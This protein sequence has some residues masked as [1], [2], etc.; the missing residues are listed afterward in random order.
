MI[1]KI[2]KFPPIVQT[3]EID[4]S[5][6]VTLFV[7][8]NNAG[9][10]YISQLVWAINN[11]DPSSSE[12]I[13]FEQDS[14]IRFI[15]EGI[16]QEIIKELDCDFMDVLSRNYSK[17]ISKDDFETIFKE[18]IDAD[19][20]VEFNLSDI[21]EKSISNV[22][23]GNNW[24]LSYSK[25]RNSLLFK[26]NIS[27]D[28]NMSS[29]VES[30]PLGILNQYLEGII[31]YNM[32]D[33]N[34]VYMPS[35]RLFLPSFYKYIYTLEKKSKDTMFKNLDILNSENKNFF[36]SSYTLPI[37]KLLNK[38]VFDIKKPNNE[39][40]YLKQLMNLIE[41]D[42]SLDISEEIGMADISY[43]HKSGKKLPMHLTS[44]MVNQL[45]TI[46]LYF[47]YWYKE[48]N[49]FLLLDEPE[50]NL[51]PSKKLELTEVLL[52]FASDNKLLMATHS[53]GIAKS[54]INYIHLFDLKE[55][56]KGKD[57]A[58]FIEENN[59]KMD[60]DI[61]LKSN[62]IAIYY[63]NGKTIT[64]YKRDDNSDIH[65]GTFTDIEKLQNKQYEYIMDMLD[66]DS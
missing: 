44:S 45:V 6:K 28:A 19:I 29:E 15:K 52:H 53:S 2:N 59:L 48:N 16:T 9:K 3:C 58:S 26:I 13:D 35:T 61:D 1:L 21:K 11:F 63:F 42:I 31:V 7:G 65:F 4:L 64:S 32:L 66:N 62:D 55:K 33:S 39:N 50:M 18:K 46:Y 34:P 51:H 10:T 14:S 40:R 57:L 5:K 37:D 36:A 49:N 27:F 8:K 23:E 17:F 20:S 24:K 43:L 56:L 54:I 38:L 47:K 30:I 41:G 60:I 22:I 12:Y 25:E